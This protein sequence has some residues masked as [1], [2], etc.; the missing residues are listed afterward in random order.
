VRIALIAIADRGSGDG[1]E[2]AIV[3]GK[4]IARHQLD[5]ALALRC[6]KVLCVGHGASPEAIDLRQAAESLGAQFQVVRGVRDLPASVRGDDQLLVLAHGLLPESPRAFALLKEGYKVLVLPAEA[7]WGAGFER[8]DLTSAWGGAMVIPGRLADH[9]DQLP[10]DAEPIAGL[11]RIARQAGVPERTLP[12]NELAEG[13]WQIVRTGEAAHAQEPAWVRR[14]LPSGAANRLTAWVA[15]YALRRFGTNLIGHSRALPVL[16]ALAGMLIVGSVAA[17]WFGYA[18]WA[19]IVLALAALSNEAVAGLV[20]LQRSIFDETSK[21]SRL[22]FV[23]RVM[24]DLALVAAGALA[25]DATRA[26]RLFPPLV[27]AGLL[28]IAPWWD[29]ADWRMLPTDRGVIA[30]LLALAAAFGFAEGAFMILALL[31]ILLRLAP[32]AGQRG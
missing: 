25:I 24:W 7:G 6:D 14:R 32:E 29:E 8:L 11:L 22:N 26:E 17:A 2:P 12:E 1:A 28:R 15:R 31:L 16:A 23:L 20:I 27:T 13:R 18:A 10:E 4:S 9:L 19:F 5:F 3:A 30:I 21:P